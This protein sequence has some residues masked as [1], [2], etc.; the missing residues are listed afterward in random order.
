MERQA[1]VLAL[2]QALVTI[3]LLGCAAIGSTI[4][5]QLGENHEHLEPKY[6]GDKN[7]STEYPLLATGQEVTEHIESGD[8]NDNS[9]ENLTFA[10]VQKK[11][12]HNEPDDDDNDDSTQS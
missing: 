1:L 5:I 11:N 4:Y 2:V 3:T 10:S 12:E 7:N 8:D 9:T 6:E